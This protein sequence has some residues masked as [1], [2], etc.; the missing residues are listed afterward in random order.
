MLRVPII[1][2]VISV[3]LEGYSEKFNNFTYMLYQIGNGFVTHINGKRKNIIDI[4]PV[5]YVAN[6][7][8]AVAKDMLTN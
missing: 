8:I 1:G 3:P 7:F 2:P 5:D 4:V 6:Y